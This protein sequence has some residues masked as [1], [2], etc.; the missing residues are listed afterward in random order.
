MKTESIVKDELTVDASRICTICGKEVAEAEFWGHVLDRH[1]LMTEEY[2]TVADNLKSPKLT[3]S[4]D[5]AEKNT[6]RKNFFD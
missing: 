5:E 2:Q 6:V 3:G 4:V 1:G